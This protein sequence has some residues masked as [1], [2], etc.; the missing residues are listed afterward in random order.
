M[1]DVRRALEV[2]PAVQDLIGFLDDPI[3]NLSGGVLVCVLYR[4]TETV[5]RSTILQK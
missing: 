1:C 5:S 3:D 2:A 4:W